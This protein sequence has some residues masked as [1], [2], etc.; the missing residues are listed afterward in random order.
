MAPSGHCTADR[1]VTGSCPYDVSH[2]VLYNTS[3]QACPSPYMPSVVISLLTIVLLIPLIVALSLIPRRLRST[4]KT[5]AKAFTGDRAVLP[6][7]PELAWLALVTIS[8][9]GGLV[10]VEAGL[11][12]R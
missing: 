6:F 9:G 1:H 11:W 5:P 2:N 7:L 12:V 8:V 4:G 3:L 10:H